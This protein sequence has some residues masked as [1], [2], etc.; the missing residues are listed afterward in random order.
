MTLDDNP[1]WA[2]YDKLRTAF[3]NVRYY[4]RRLQQTERL[5]FT[6]DIILAISAPS[7]AVAK[8]W[9]WD[10][11]IGNIAWTI[12]LIIAAFVSVAKPLLNLSKRIKNYE[13]LVF[14]YRMLHFDLYEIKTSVETSKK[15]DKSLQLEFKKSLQREKT[16]IGNCQET[17]EDVAV[18]KQAENETLDRYPV[19]SFFVPKEV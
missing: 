14:G 9:V 5:N 11:N 12:L 7:S 8:L 6:L 15:Y 2:V 3:L 4:E 16:L 17:H 1:V 10:S 13:T 19:E 18:K